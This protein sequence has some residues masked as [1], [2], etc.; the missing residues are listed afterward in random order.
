LKSLADFKHHIQLHRQ[1]VVKLGM[2]L[3]AE[4]YTELDLIAVERFLKLHDR[5]KILN[6]P[7]QLRIFGYH[8]PERPMQR[9]FEF[10]GQQER[11]A[12]QSQQLQQVVND[13]NDLDLAISKRFFAASFFNASE[14]DRFYQIEKVADLVDRS[15][16]PV[17]AEEFGHPMILASEYI[18]DPNL[19]KLSLWLESRYFKVT[20]GLFYPLAEKVLVSKQA[21]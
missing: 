2:T 16:D 11:S 19:A 18:R 7:A 14:M 21:W 10:F 13:I 9:L 3:A 4:Y 5:S 6:S 17:A 20:E 15:L 8:H 1:R 12:L